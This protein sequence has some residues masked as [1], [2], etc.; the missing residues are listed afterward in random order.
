MRTTTKPVVLTIIFNVYRFPHSQ[1]DLLRQWIANMHSVDFMPSQKAVV[2][3]DHFSDEC[4]NKTGQ[5]TRL[6]QGA[7]PTIFTLHKHIVKV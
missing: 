4:F 5:T 3:S 6:R 1:P 2:C 7:V